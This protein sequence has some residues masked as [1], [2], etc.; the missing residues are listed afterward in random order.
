MA[1]DEKDL[2]SSVHNDLSE[3]KTYRATFEATWN[4]IVDFMMPRMNGFNRKPEPGKQR[5]TRIFDSTAPLALRNFQAAIDSMITPHTQ[6]WHRLSVDAGQLDDN[7]NVRA[8]LDAVVKKLFAV[9]YS[10]R[11]GFTT[12]IG[13]SY[14]SLGLFGNGPLM[15]EE[16]KGEGIRYRARPLNRFYFVENA[17][18]FVDKSCDCWTLTARQAVQK[19]GRSKLPVHMVN[20]YDRTPE[21]KF[22]FVHRVQPRADRVAGRL[23]ALNM[24]FESVWVW[25]GELIDRSGF[26][27]YPYAVGRFYVD[28]ETQYG[29]SP[30]E[31]AL[32]D[33]KMVNEMEKTIIRGAQK[34]VDP[35]LLLTED[36]V[37]EGFDLRS[38]ALNHGGLDNSGN[39]LVKPLQLG[40]N[41]QAGTA[42][43]DSK[44]ATI[45]TGFYVTLFQILTEAPQMTATEVLERAQEKGILLAPTMGRVQTEM[46]GQ[47]I[48]RELDICGHAPGVLPPMPPELVE[49]GASVNIVYDSPLNKAMRASEGTAVLQWVQQVATVAQLDQSALKVINGQEVARGLADIGGVPV[50]Y[51]VSE[52]Q[53]AA[54]QAQEAQTAQLTNIL[55][56][57][58]QAASAA[59]DLAAAAQMSGTPGV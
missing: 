39:Q 51:L 22:E 8:Y 2:V 31:D 14:Q 54:Q 44:R 29:G 23:D 9:R 17:A 13:Q 25:N 56:A 11:S 53:I 1:A 15:I 35:P 46:L 24:A 32:P 18:G 58:P 10:W 49:A 19:W 26:R 36:G 30:A 7:E 52:D 59:K 48:E 41:I 42:Y 45:N 4:E 12:Q 21:A 6:V 27:T 38:G 40:E 37:L 47:M 34:A 55:N 20:A 28:S 50:K 33:I 57:A 5:N 3:M 16:V 43:A